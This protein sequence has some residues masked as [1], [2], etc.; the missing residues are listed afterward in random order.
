QHRLIREAYNDLRSA[1]GG[2]YMR[3]HAK[4]TKSGAAGGR[5]SAITKKE[6]R[7]RKIQIVRRIY[8]PHYKNASD[9]A[10]EIARHPIWSKEGIERPSQ[11]TIRT[12]L[13]EIK[14]QP[15]VR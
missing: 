10:G 11:R 9:H 5:E 2:A 15:S 8:N 7:E 14:Q 12:Y 13:K 6:E 1:F 4:A 3:Q